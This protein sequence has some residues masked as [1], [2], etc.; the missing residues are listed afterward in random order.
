MDIDKYLQL[1][2]SFIDFVQRIVDED[3]SREGNMRRAAK[4]LGFLVD[5]TLVLTEDV[6]SN[7]LMDYMLFEKNGSPNRLIDRYSKKNADT[8][9]ENDK[10]LLDSILNH[11]FSLFEVKEINKEDC[12]LKMFDLLGKQ[13]LTLLDI[14][15]SKTGKIG[16]LFAARI[17]PA[18]DV[19]ITSGLILGFEKNKQLRLLTEISRQYRKPNRRRSLKLKSSKKTST[20]LIEVMYGAYK[21]WGIKTLTFEH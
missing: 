7:M 16:S 15:L 20:T 12:T 9:D 10:I 18:E 11:H 21:K 3:I 6:E 17:V 1:R 8:L 2:R 4:R 13:N 5:N 14:G 19:F